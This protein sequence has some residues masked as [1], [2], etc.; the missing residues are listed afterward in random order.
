MESH[1]IVFP[2]DIDFVNAELFIRSVLEANYIELPVSVFANTPS[3]EHCFVIE[4]ELLPRI[5]TKEI[6]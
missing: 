4:R 2:W 1:K 5:D 3:W 6:S